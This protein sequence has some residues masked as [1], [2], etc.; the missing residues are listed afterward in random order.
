MRASALAEYERLLLRRNDPG[1]GPSLYMRVPQG[2]GGGSCRPECWYHRVASVLHDIGKPRA[3]PEGRIL[4]AHEGFKPGTGRVSRTADGA[5][6][7]EPL[8]A[9]IDV[10]PPTEQPGHVPAQAFA[11][12]SR[13]A[14]AEAIDPPMGGGGREQS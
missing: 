3:D 14:V 11:R 12:A 1:P 7:P 13:P 2:S 5:A 10:A 9:W 4:W 8:P 6:M